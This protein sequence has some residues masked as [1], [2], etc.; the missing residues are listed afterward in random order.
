MLVRFDRLPM[1]NNHDVLGFEKGID[2][3]FDGMLRPGMASWS[4]RMP[5]VEVAEFPAETV[6]VA[7]LPG[8]SK[9]D[10]KISFEKGLLTISGERK[11][12]A[13]PEG[14]TLVRSELRHGSFTRSFEFGHEVNADAISAELVDG[15]LRVIVPKSEEARPKQIAVKVK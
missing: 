9:E 15:I 12:S 11:P 10:V 4:G 3:L 2:S 5:A 8:V 14:A 7:E 13:V 1:L 6:I